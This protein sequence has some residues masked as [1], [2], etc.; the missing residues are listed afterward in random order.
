LFAAL[1]A[2]PGPEVD[3]ELAAALGGGS[4]AVRRDAALLLGRRRATKHATDLLAL[5][6]D[7]DVV[8]RRSAIRALREMAAPDDP[9]PLLDWLVAAPDWGEEDE[10]LAGIAEN[11]RRRDDAPAL[12]EGV[13]AAWSTVTAERKRRL[14]VRVLAT[15][16]A[17]ATLAALKGLLATDLQTEV[18]VALAEELAAWTSADA[19]PTLAELHKAANP[20]R[21]RFAAYVG[22]VR[23]VSIFEKAL[24]ARLDLLAKAVASAPRPDDRRFV[25]EECAR[26]G[27]VRALGLISGAMAK[28][29]GGPHAVA[30]VTQLAPLTLEKAYAKTMACMEEAL[31]GVELSREA[32]AETRAT[33]QTALK[34]S[35]SQL[36]RLA[37]EKKLVTIETKA[38]DPDLDL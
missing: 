16:H 25:F 15:R 19:R 12:A 10:L 2:M 31:S 35:L 29:M 5:R 20:E 21:V 28:D 30:A 33:L 23:N 1:A 26:L 3:A 14:L 6:R 4:P 32:N 11:A 8:T 9:T 17:P 13:R 7:P 38:A 36:Q 24:E 22:Y 37:A 34:A 27:D 18:K